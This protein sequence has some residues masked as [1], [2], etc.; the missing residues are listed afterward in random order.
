MN[1][2]ITGGAGYVGTELLAKLA[3]NKEISKITIYDNL[4]KGH[5]SLFL[6][7]K[8]PFLSKIEFVHG[9]ILDSRL[10]KK[11]LTDT[12]VL[13]HLAAMVTTPFANTDPH[14]F[15]QV[16]HWGTAEVVYAAEESGVSKFIHLSSTAVYGTG[17]DLADE[18]TLPLPQT[19]YGISK[20]RGE[21]HVNRLMEKKN[22]IILRGGNIYGFSKSM[23]FDAVINKFMFDAHFT[24]RIQIFGNGKQTRAFIHIEHLVN[25]IEQC[26]LKEVPTGTY[27]LVDKNLQILEI[28]DVLKELYPDLEFIYAN[29]H[30]KLRELNVSLESKL[31]ES[32]TRFTSTSLSDELQVFK[33]QFAF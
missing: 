20:L 2:L 19:Y 23:R 14:F 30:M 15:E 12:D 13:I 9:E 11:Q 18:S 33:S 1:V 32:V 22:S 26:V 21:T 5:R 6:G 29:Q 3:L 8:S 25:T 16:N 17:A 10:L 31:F 7:K 4:S 27:N 24:N 28:L